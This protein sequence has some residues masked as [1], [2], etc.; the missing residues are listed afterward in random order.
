MKTLLKLSMVA[1]IASTV[2][3]CAASSY[4]PPMQAQLDVLKT[5]TEQVSK[6]AKQ[7]HDLADEA[8]Q[9][10]NAAEAAANRAAEAAQG[11]SNRLDTIFKH[12]MMK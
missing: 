10:A 2:V 3:G 11:T 6:D 12:H 1:L 9:R 8:A 4:I 5:A 7:A